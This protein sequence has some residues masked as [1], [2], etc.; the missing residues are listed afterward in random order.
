MDTAARLE[1]T[2]VSYLLKV[3]VKV[4]IVRFQLLTYI[5]KSHSKHSM[6]VS[7]LLLISSLHCIQ[8]R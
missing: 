6:P 8:Q 7:K 4:L 1:L 2:S 3:L 5:N